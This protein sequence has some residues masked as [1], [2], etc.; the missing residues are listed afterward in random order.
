M[1][2]NSRASGCPITGVG[3]QVSGEIINQDD[4]KGPKVDVSEI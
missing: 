2:Y 3:F 1:V 4:Y